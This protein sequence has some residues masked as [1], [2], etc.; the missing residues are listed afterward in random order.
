MSVVGKPLIFT[1]FCSSSSNGPRQKQIILASSACSRDSCDGDTCE[2][3]RWWWV[4][5]NFAF[6]MQVMRTMPLWK[7]WTPW[8]DVYKLYKRGSH[9][10]ETVWVLKEGENWRKSGSGCGSS[11]VAT[12]QHTWPLSACKALVWTETCCQCKMTHR[13]K[14]L[15]QNQNVKYLINYYFD[16]GLKWSYFGWTGVNKMYF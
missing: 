7:F 13:F 14:V 8:T 4:V 6:W 9:G 12:G 2:C 3:A 11:R 1:V 5:N 15:V 16:G 10:R